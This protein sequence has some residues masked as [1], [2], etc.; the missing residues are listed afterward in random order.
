MRV[1]AEVSRSPAQVA[2]QWVARRAPNVIPIIGARRLSQLEDNLGALDFALSAEQMAALTAVAPLPREY[3]HSFW[4][5][6]IRRDLI[7]GRRVDE[8]DSDE[9]RVTSYE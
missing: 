4:N 9:L 8:L 1:A 5:D 6:F 7:Y 2:I 3:P